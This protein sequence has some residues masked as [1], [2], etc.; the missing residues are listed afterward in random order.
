MKPLLFTL[1]LIAA[2]DIC[3]DAQ[4][5]SAPDK[6]IPIVD[7]AT[8]SSE[9]RPW[10][11]WWWHGSAL[12][13]AGI[14][15]EL[16]A[17]QKA[18]LGG[19]EITPIYGV[20][21]HEDKFVNFLSP[22]WMD[23]LIHSLKEAERLNLGVDMATGTGWPFGG[24]WVAAQHA[25]KNIRHKVYQVAGGHRLQE[26]IEFI[27]PPYLKAIGNQIHR[28]DDHA[29]A[30]EVKD[31]VEPISANKDLQTLALDQVQ[32]EKPLPLQTLMGYGSAGEV[33]DLT[34][35]VDTEGILN[36]VAPPGQWKL[37]ALFQGWHGKMVERA[38]PGGEGNVIDHFSTE[39][40]T[41]Y[42][43]RFDSAF[44]KSD[45]T[46]LRAFFN[47]SYEVDDARGVADWTP[48]LLQEFQTRRGYDLREHLPAL[49]NDDNNEKNQ[50]VLCDYRETLSEL[51]LENFTKRWKDW[52]NKKN[53]LTRNQAHGSPANILDLYSVVDIPEIEGIEPLRIKMASS[54]ANVSGKK[55]I[56]AEAAT[57]LNEHFK[58]TLGDIKVALD[59]FLLNGVNHLVYH[60]TA[61]S[62]VSEPWPGWLFYAA[63][64]LNP[65]NPLWNDFHTLNAY[66][67]RCQ[68]ILQ[69][70]SADNDVL[71]YY[72]VHDRFSI[73]G[74]ELIE[75]FDGIGKQF[76]GTSFARCAQFM[77]E[78]GYAFDY[79]SDNQI[80][81]L[82]VSGT[83]MVTQGNA[84]YQTIVIPRC[85]YIPL[86]TLEKIFQMSQEGAHVVFFEGMPETF[87]G[88]KDLE[89]NSIQFRAVQQSIV[90]QEGE[91]SI[92]KSEK[93]KL[94]I[95]TNLSRLLSETFCR[96]ESI[97]EKGISVL[98][99]KDRNGMFLYLINNQKESLFKGWVTLN[100]YANEVQIYDPMTGVSG[101]ALRETSDKKTVR[102][103][104]QLAGNQSLIV[105]GL[106]EGGEDDL[107]P[108]YEPAGEPIDISGKW[109]VRFVSGGPQLPAPLETDTLASWTDFGS[110]GHKSF[111][112]SAIYSITFR[113]PRSS[114]KQMVLDLGAVDESAEI[115]INGQGLG[116][117]ICAPYKVVVPSSI[118]KKK[119]NLEVRVSNLMINRI[120]YMDRR[121]IFWKKFYNV[122]FPAK[123][124][125]NRKGGL[126]D[127]SPIQP[128][129]S[130]LIGPVQL[131]PVQKLTSSRGLN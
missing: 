33:V 125:E 86:P 53:A 1:T 95:G 120:A 71:L 130:G 27:Q 16:E 31:V 117:V 47:D 89:K 105:K 32:F 26:K 72:P 66:V 91:F 121:K 103:Y 5:D 48:T 30:M 38:G 115:F 51:L 61:Y 23:L 113:H 18:G 46:S 116:T 100:S 54:A 63:V 68:S 14:T 4:V 65:R 79:I 73:P 85:K 106:P 92:V 50:R 93:G 57:W 126:F 97:V 28:I 128:E 15:Y 9:T 19:V 94:M 119:N 24:P 55:L 6:E 122:N 56:S 40:L 104:I 29:I 69:N 75:H 45:I 96:R 11:R 99:K 98:R 8:A 49:F 111:S 109:N 82:S 114:A 21:G 17:F 88:Y 25:C 36:W 39:A 43:S 81:Q 90:G 67:T 70:S 112:G 76:E 7:G 59:R 20:H 2:I 123:F 87:S 124:A 62:P 37:Y 3:S 44:R 102:V 12:T 41:Q 35:K 10:T 74:G 131:V 58:S 80:K 13:K 84:R 83:T 107:F 129:S 108:F 52:A 22:E 101:K 60:G 127:A 78:N 64:H 42:L 110:E 118:L 34:G 77:L